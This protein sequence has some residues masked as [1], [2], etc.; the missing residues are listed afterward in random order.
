MILANDVG[1]LLLFRE[2]TDIASEENYDI[3]LYWN[4]SSRSLSL[5]LS[6]GQFAWAGAS[7][8]HGK[9]HAR[10]VRERRHSLV[11]DD[12]KLFGTDTCRRWPF[13]FLCSCRS[14]LS[15]IEQFIREIFRVA[16]RTARKLVGQAPRVWQKS[17][18]RRE[19][20]RSL[21]NE[22]EL[23]DSSSGVLIIA[24][25]CAQCAVHRKPAD[26]APN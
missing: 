12:N 10:I 17:I 16:A 20:A 25:R 21:R 18:R 7:S 23:R 2:R 1:T 8:A 14:T 3:F 15:V 9:I 26:V 19:N 22:R 13:V 4:P 11:Y 5:S 24:H 6:H